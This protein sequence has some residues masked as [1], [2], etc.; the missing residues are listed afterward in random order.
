MSSSEPISL[1]CR[2]CN[3]AMQMDS[4]FYAIPHGQPR[5]GNTVVD[6]EEAR[7]VRMF[8]CPNPECLSI[9]LKDPGCWPE[10]VSL[11]QR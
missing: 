11:V 8:R 1:P 4:E 3:S 7:W 2:R 9:E 6:L 5:K 10:I